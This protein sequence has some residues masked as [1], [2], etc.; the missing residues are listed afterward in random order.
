[1]TSE[2]LK[3]MTIK[4]L[5]LETRRRAVWHTFTSLSGKIASCIFSKPHRN[6]SYRHVEQELGLRNSQWERD[7]V[8]YSPVRSPDSPP[9]LYEYLCFT[10]WILFYH[11]KGGNEFLRNANIYLLNY[12]TSHPSRRYFSRVKKK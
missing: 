11:E 4:Q 2:V 1:M 6:G 12:T 3:A 10:V 8:S 9:T 7:R 5:S